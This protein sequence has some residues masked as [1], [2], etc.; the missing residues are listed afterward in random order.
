MTSS[1]NNTKYHTGNI[2]LINSIITVKKEISTPENSLQVALYLIVEILSLSFLEN[3]F[4]VLL[5][6][7]S[8]FFASILVITC[9]KCIS[10]GTEI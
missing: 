7:L 5:C 1:H 4:L 6:F 9:K 3:V 2:H 10:A 8:S